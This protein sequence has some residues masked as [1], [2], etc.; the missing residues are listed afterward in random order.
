MMTEL[1]VLKP[2]T[3]TLMKELQEVLDIKEV[4]KNTPSSYTLLAPK[5]V[6]ISDVIPHCGQLNITT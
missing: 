1:E 5:M 3:H 2:F 4:A 6:M